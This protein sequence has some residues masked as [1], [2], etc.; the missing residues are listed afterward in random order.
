MNAKTQGGNTAADF[1]DKVPGILAGME[2]D[3]KL[4]EEAGD[5]KKA[6]TIRRDIAKLRRQYDAA[7][8]GQADRRA[9]ADTHAHDMLRSLIAQ[10]EQRLAAGGE[11]E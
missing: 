7:L 4:F 10:L 6:A 3:A 9:A 11:H 5:P 1:M 2:V 8:A